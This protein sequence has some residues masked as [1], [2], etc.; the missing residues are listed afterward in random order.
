MERKIPTV[1]PNK[2]QVGVI[3]EERLALRLEP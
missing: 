3:D 2:P 1:K